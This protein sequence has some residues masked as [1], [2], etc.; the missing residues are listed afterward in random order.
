[1]DEFLLDNENRKTLLTKQ[2]ND[3]VKGLKLK[4]TINDKRNINDKFV[5]NAELDASYTKKVG[6]NWTGTAIGSVGT[7]IPAKVGVRLSRPISF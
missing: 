6:K 3:L 4:G 7:D 5:P 1:M 2:V